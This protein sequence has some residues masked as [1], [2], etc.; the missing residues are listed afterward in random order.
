MDE[1]SEQIV[2]EFQR[3]RKATWK[4]ARWWLALTFIGII[5]FEV[6]FWINRDKLHTE[7]G[8]LFRR[9]RLSAEDETEG[10]FTL[11]LVSLIAIGTGIIGAT[12]AVRRHYR[13]PKCNEVPMGTWSIFGPASFGIRRGVNLNPTQCPNC[14]AMLK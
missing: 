5:G 6:P 3:R 9:D 2:S 4:A 13:C 7:K 8:I 14:G 10:Q 1:R 12:Y 11:G